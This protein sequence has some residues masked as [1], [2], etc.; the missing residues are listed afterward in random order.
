[1]RFFFAKI[2][3]GGAGVENPRGLDA[4]P[5]TCPLTGEPT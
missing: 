5:V 2:L 4:R 1:M 3:S